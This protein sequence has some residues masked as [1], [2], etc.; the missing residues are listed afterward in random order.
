MVH[1]LPHDIP[2]ALDK[3]GEIGRLIKQLWNEVRKAAGGDPAKHAA[4]HRVLGSDPLQRPLAPPP[5]VKVGGTRISSD[6]G[7]GPSFMREDAQSRVETG[8]P[9]GMANANA[10]G[11]SDKAPRLDHQHKRDVRVKR[12]G[13]DVGTRNAID[14]GDGLVATD[15]AT[16]DVVH[17]ATPAIGSSSVATIAD[18][19]AFRNA[20][21]L[22]LT[23]VMAQ[24]FR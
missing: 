16:N 4:T 6:I 19:N 18:Y 10:E 13:V 9:S 22:C 14:L 2:P 5:F 3:F 24:N 1:I 15:D 17:I 21:A 11:S 8:V 23:Q 20:Q 12:S 7:T